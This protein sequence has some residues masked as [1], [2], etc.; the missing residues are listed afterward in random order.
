MS[1]EKKLQGYAPEPSMFTDKYGR[2]IDSE[3]GPMPSPEEFK[4]LWE[5]AQP[6][7]QLQGEIGFGKIMVFGTVENTFYEKHY[8]EILENSFYNPNFMNNNANQHSAENTINKQENMNEK[9][10]NNMSERQKSKIEILL[11]EQQSQI[12]RLHG[13]LCRTD[14]MCNLINGDGSKFKE[15]PVS[16]QIKTTFSLNERIDQNNFQIDHLIDALEK[17]LLIIN[18]FI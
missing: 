10:E 4:K 1:E 14:E 17:D 5:A 3:F 7:S 16:D 12:N 2:Y 15:E 11:G 6:K 18:Q 13:L 8:N 9:V